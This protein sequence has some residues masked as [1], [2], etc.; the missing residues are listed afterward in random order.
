MERA[1]PAAALIFNKA[2][3]K[4]RTGQILFIHAAEGFANGTNQNVL[5]DEDIANIVTAYDAWENQER[6]AAW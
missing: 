4:D 2:K 3:R 5:R 1:S 6:Y